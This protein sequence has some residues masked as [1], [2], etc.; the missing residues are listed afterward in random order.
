VQFFKKNCHE[1]ERSPHPSCESGNDKTC[2]PIDPKYPGRWVAP[3]RDTKPGDQILGG[4]N[5]KMAYKIPDVT[6]EHGVIQVY[7]LTQNTCNAPD[8]FMD[9]Y[10]Y[11]AAWAGCPCDGG[12]TGAHPTQKSCTAVG[13]TPEEFF[14]CA[15]VRVTAGGSSGGGASTPSSVSPRSNVSSAKTPAVTTTMPEVSIETSTPSAD[16][17]TSSTDANTTS[18]DSTTTPTDSTA[19]PSDSSA[20]EDCLPENGADDESNLDASPSTSSP[21]TSSATTKACTV[22]NQYM[23]PGELD[24]QPD[25]A[26]CAQDWKQ[27]GGTTYKGP[28]NCC[29]SKQKCVKL[30]P[31]YHQC[32]ASA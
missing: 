2:G 9:K 31:Y 16:V 29:N 4:P 28:T 10:K 20:E 18:T 13:Q 3:C 6:M 21:T 23:A 14:N 7:W 8:G 26:K 15:D 17:T 1:L 32:K 24:K 22:G 27:C 11:P 25:N 30:N 12:A 19:T 5:G